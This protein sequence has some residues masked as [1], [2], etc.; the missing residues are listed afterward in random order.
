MAALTAAQQ[1]GRTPPTVLDA[2]TPSGQDEK[3][4]AALMATQEAGRTAPT[5]V[6]VGAPIMKI[7]RREETM[8]AL[9]A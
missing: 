4:M 1:T 3:T 6:K 8:A 9:M 5:A 2:G 7:C